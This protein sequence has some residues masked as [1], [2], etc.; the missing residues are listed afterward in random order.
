MQRHHKDSWTCWKESWDVARSLKLLVI[1][2]SLSGQNR[3]LCAM[4]VWLD[5]STW[6]CLWPWKSTLLA[7]EGDVE[8]CPKF[9]RLGFPM[10][11]TLE[12][13]QWDSRFGWIFVTIKILWSTVGLRWIG[14]ALNNG[15]VTWIRHAI[16]QVVIGSPA[17]PPSPVSLQIHMSIAI[18]QIMWENRISF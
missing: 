17:L 5:K 12:K 10:M 18:S 3:T 9:S 1:G 6:I 2:A 16:H 7:L 15:P 11:S 4:P 14:K 8:Y 13:N